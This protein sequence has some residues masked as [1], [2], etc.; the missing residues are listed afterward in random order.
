MLALTQNLFGLL[1]KILQKT[2]Q[3]SAEFSA[4]IQK[5]ISKK[6]I[7]ILYSNFKIFKA[8]TLESNNFLTIFKFNLCKKPVVYSLG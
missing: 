8:V 2:L 6:A 7:N 3:S 5:N 1:N 4:E